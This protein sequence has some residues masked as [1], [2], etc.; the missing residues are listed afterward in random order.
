MENLE[1]I[2]VQIREVCQSCKDNDKLIYCN[3]CNSSRYR[4]KWIPL[5]D[6]LEAMWE[7]PIKGRTT[8]HKNDCSLAYGHPGLHPVTIEALEARYTSKESP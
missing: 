5:Q 2:Q 7:V 3:K 8:C 4:L 6:L 1:N